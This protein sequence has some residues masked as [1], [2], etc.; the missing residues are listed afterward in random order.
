M[1]KAVAGLSI[2]HVDLRLPLATRETVVSDEMVIV[3]KMEVLRLEPGW[4][5]ADDKGRQRR[6]ALRLSEIQGPM[7]LKIKSW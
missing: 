3:V 7:T 5:Q 4:H 6:S 2:L 1:D